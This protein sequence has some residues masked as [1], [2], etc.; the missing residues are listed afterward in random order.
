MLREDI[1]KKQHELVLLSKTN[2]VD[3]VWKAIRPKPPNKPV[4]LHELKYAGGDVSRKLSW[5]RSEL[6]NVGCSSIIVTKLDEIA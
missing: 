6:V 1:S 5:L 3:E 4:R 2:L